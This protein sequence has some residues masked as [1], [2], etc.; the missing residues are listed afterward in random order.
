VH[1]LVLTNF[2]LIVT[3]LLMGIRP[4]PYALLPPVNNNGEVYM[5]HSFQW[6]TGMQ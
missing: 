3:V 6:C 4:E 5:T 2:P 1:V